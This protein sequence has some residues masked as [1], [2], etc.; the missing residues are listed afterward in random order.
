M[1]FELFLCG[2][3]EY[4]GAERLSIADCAGTGTSCA[5]RYRRLWLACAWVGG[6]LGFRGFA[7]DGRVL[8][9][10]RPV[11]HDAESVED[12]GCCLLL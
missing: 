12:Y 9:M 2:H 4:L 1:G 6:L 10:A 5:M 7:R 11:I 8:R 3:W